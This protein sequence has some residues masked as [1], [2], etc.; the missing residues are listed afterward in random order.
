MQVRRCFPD[1]IYNE[2]DT[3]DNELN[4][5]RF[6]ATNEVWIEL[7]ASSVRGNSGVP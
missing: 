5:D 3:S 2:N 6:N 4:G 1:E 7:L